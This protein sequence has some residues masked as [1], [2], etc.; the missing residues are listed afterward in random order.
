MVKLKNSIPN[1]SSDSGSNPTNENVAAFNDEQSNEMLPKSDSSSLQRP[2]SPLVAEFIA[3]GSRKR[4]A[5][6]LDSEPSVEAPPSVTESDSED[7]VL[8]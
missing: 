4:K 7:L 1:Q 2:L 6:H 5:D 8:F 3:E